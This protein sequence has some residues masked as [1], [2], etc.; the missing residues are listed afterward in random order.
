MPVTLIVPGCS[1]CV[2]AI[3]EID[4]L[5]VLRSGWIRTGLAITRSD[6]TLGGRTEGNVKHVR[7]S[8][9]SSCSSKGLSRI[10]SAQTKRDSRIPF[11]LFAL[12]RALCAG[13]F[14][15]I[16]LFS[17]LARVE[18]ATA[19]TS[20]SSRSCAMFLDCTG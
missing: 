6:A 13:G 17:T 4:V 2:F 15:L 8:S 1:S 16:A 10:D 7:V 3:V 12:T 20:L 11:A 9:M 18:T 5:L 19:A 14:L